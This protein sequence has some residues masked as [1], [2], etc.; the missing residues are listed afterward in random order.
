MRVVDGRPRPVDGAVSAAVSHLHVEV[1]KSA[2][3][4]HAGSGWPPVPLLTSLIAAEAASRAW[5]K[6]ESEIA[7]VGSQQ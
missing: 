5:E 1:V 4:H 3:A 7:R 6:R 2:V